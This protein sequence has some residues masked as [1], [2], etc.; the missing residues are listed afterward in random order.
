MTEGMMGRG[1][2]TR[3]Y[4]PRSESSHMY[5]DN[6]EEDKYGLMDAYEQDKAKDKRQA[7]KEKEENED[8]RIKHIK[9]KPH[10][11]TPSSSVDD[12]LDD[13]DD[14]DK[15]DAEREITAQ[16]GPPGNGGFLTS[17]AAQAKG[18]GAAG[19]QMV[20][21]S[22][23]MEHAWSDLLKRNRGDWE[24]STGPFHKPEGGFGRQ[25]TYSPKRAKHVRRQNPTGPM[26]FGH[27]TSVEYSH[28]G[29][30][31]KQP[32][33]QAEPRQYRRMIDYMREKKK[34]LGNV[35]TTTPLRTLQDQ[36]TAPKIPGMGGKRPRLHPH[37]TP[38][39]T[40]PKNL[41]TP[42]LTKP[43]MP[44][45]VTMSEDS[46]PQD[47]LLKAVN[48]YHLAELRNIM[49]EMR[50]LLRDKRNDKKKMAEKDVSGGASSLPKYNA[51]PSDK[52]SKPTGP[53]E[54][55]ANIYAFKP[56]GV[57]GGTA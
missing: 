16:T 42:H 38:S 43:K 2:D 22:E 4:A 31:V 13:D 28:R 30:S 34:H 24:S 55:D 51:G 6:H 10:H 46:L 17:L 23:P 3:M 33:K 14:W 27:D 48:K 12:T 52:T 39:I 19:G 18:S 40:P 5:R 32:S 54:S 57:R 37:R 11:V 50:N 56:E 35:R 36:F 15:K 1:S 25:G 26:A 29:L 20:Q 8:K 7:K 47:T 49:R 9:I 53:T 41:R 45:M 44:S 21:M